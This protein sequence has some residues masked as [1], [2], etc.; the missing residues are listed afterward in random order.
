[1]EGVGSGPVRNRVRLDALLLQRGLYATREQARRAILAGEVFVDGRLESK[2]GASVAD[3]AE[4][5]VRQQA[6]RYVSRGGL[7]LEKALQVFDVLV[8]GR[9]ALDVGAS[10][11]GFTDC[12]LQ[13]GARHVWAVDVGYG[14]L[15]WQLRN[16]PRVSVLERTNIRS[17]EAGSIPPVDIATIDVAFISLSKVLPAVVG[18]LVPEG[19]IVALVKP[20]FEAGREFVG[21]RGVVRDPQVQ[22]RV[23]EN[24]IGCAQCLELIVCALTHSPIK[25]PQG[26][27]E[28]L[29][30]MS[31]RPQSTAEQDMKSQL[32]AIV[33]QAH[34]ELN[35]R[36]P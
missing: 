17:L 24:V 11:G 26:N 23:L 27:I 5:E 13:H 6:P 21:K 28:F 4:I 25:G 30:Y 8:E 18:L 32:R 22:V 9:D 33:D 29:M 1:M 15:D 14:Q 12:L 10:T 35:S 20:Q 7:K 16:D 34:Q 31:K 36:E 3:T 19:D 2:A